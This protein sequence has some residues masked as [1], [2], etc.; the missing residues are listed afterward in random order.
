MKNRILI[1]G[2]KPYTKISLD[3]TIDTFP[4]NYRLNL[5]LPNNNNGT[6]YNHL[7]VCSHLRDNLLPKPS[8]STVCASSILVKVT[9]PIPPGEWFINEYIHAYKEDYLRAYVKRWNAEASR[10]FQSKFFVKPDMRRFNAYLE[11]EG[12]PYKFEGQPRTGI[13]LVLSQIF[14]GLHKIFATNFSIHHETRTSHYV[15]EGCFESNCHGSAESEINILRW[16]HENNKVDA[17]LCLL[18][19]S[20]SPVL[21]C[22]GLVPSEFIIDLLKSTM[23]KCLVK[24]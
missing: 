22:N 14:Q 12:S 18:E 16:L 4:I 9:P 23:G 19:D 3:Q 2:N 21:K 24:D 10:A 15:K 17:S 1:I 6:K 5:S 20:S 13:S 7:G 11:E 8:I